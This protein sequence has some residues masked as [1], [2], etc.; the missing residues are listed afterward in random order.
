MATSELQKPRVFI[1]ADALFAGAASPSDHGAS[2]VVLR[3]AEIT[4]I[5]AFASEQV[6]AETER[7]LRN[8]LPKALPAF[9]VLVQ[10]CLQ[11]VPDPAVLETE[12]HIG[13]ADAKDLPI[14]VAAL[15]EGCPWLITFNVRDYQPGD[16]AVTVLSP[17]DFV[18]E[19]RYLLGRLG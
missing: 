13:K 15:R 6:I 11:I 16:P 8:K 5:D 2:L 17:G 14:L 7:N 10:R 4:L 12:R 3:M 1:D 18:Q 19:I 9:R